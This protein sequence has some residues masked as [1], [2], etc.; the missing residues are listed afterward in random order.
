MEKPLVKLNNRIINLERI[1]VA[2]LDQNGTVTIDFQ[3]GGGVA[4]RE[5]FAGIEGAR[6][7]A[8]LSSVVH[9]LKLE[10]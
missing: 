6:L 8:Y 4:V 9:E 10:G 1:T 2:T 3:T 5:L 7:W